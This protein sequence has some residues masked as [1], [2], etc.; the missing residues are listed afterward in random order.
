MGKRV[1]GWLAAVVTSLAVVP[2]LAHAANLSE[3]VR[4]SQLTAADI[5]V[6]SASR[7]DARLISYRLR[8]P[9]LVDDVDLFVILPTGYDEHPDRRYPVI[10]F[11]HGGFGKPQDWLG[12]GV[13]GGQ[14]RELTEGLDAIAVIV[15]GGNGGWAADYDN[16]GRGGPPAWDTFNARQV[17]PWVDANFRT[18]ADRG[19]RAILGL[20]TGGHNSMHLSAAHPDLYSFA[21]SFSGATDIVSNPFVW[22]V[23]G[24]E[25]MADGQAF[26]APFGSRIN[27]AP[28]WRAANAVDLAENYQAQRIWMSTGN[29]LP[30]WDYWTKEIFLIPDV[31]E[32]AVN[33]M[34]GS[35]HS[36]LNQL[37]VEHSFVDYGP[38][39][40]NYNHWNESLRRVLPQMIASF[41]NPPKPPSQ[42][43]FKSAELIYDIYG[44]RVVNDRP[45]RFGWT[46]LVNA[47]ASGF[48]FDGLNAASITTPALYRPGSTRRVTVGGLQ[49]TMRADPAGRLTIKVDPGAPGSVSVSIR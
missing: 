24:L 27:D 31:V 4:M 38:G 42:V 12:D 32:L 21:A 16:F 35:L 6:L 23:I 48:R 18:L 49:R 29:G 44:F 22:I 9:A 3:V 28:G 47:D 45:V 39:G 43:T 46:R 11:Q 20:S 25:A 5:Q 2:G 8:T 7:N 13:K 41:E 19:H 15:P 30:G 26:D 36:R 17:V 14:A 37:G 33:Q 1:C 10:Y 34:S 40:H